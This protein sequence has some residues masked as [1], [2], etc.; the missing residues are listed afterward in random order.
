MWRRETG[1]N[2]RTWTVF[3]RNKNGR[4]KRLTLGRLPKWKTR[5]AAEISAE[6]LL[7]LLNAKVRAGAPVAANRLRALVSRIF[8]FGAG[9]RLIA[10]TANPVIG[11]KK[12][13]K[14]TTRDRVL[15]DDETRIDREL[16][17]RR[18]DDSVRCRGCRDC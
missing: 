12:P 17:R 5:P 6:D 13:T 10:P 11:V 9:Q 1:K 16:G 7:A 3:Y 18:C 4:Q 15:T 14:E 8:T 2:A